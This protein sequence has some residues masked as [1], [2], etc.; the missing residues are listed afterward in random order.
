MGYGYSGCGYSRWHAE[1]GV[2]VIDKEEEPA[3]PPV[4]QQAWLPKDTEELRN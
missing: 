3:V 2:V 1:D 4:A